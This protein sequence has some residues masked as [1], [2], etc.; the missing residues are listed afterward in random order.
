MQSI[1]EYCIR[2]LAAYMSLDGVYFLDFSRA[3]KELDLS[4]V[5]LQC[6][7]QWFFVIVQMYITRVGA[8]M[9]STS[10]VGTLSISVS[11]VSPSL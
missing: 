6:G 9:A 11:V 4:F 3:C 2:Y 10:H 7:T 5:T 1:S 8:I